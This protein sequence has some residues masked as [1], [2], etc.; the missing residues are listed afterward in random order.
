MCRRVRRSGKVSAYAVTVGDAV[1]HTFRGE[2]LR[3]IMSTHPSRVSLVVRDH[4]K[5]SISEAHTLADL[6]Q[7]GGM[8][9]VKLLFDKRSHT[10]FV[11]LPREDGMSPVS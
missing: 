10:R 4:A 8:Q 9:P 2:W 5:A 1:G 11:R 6:R 7:T 3:R